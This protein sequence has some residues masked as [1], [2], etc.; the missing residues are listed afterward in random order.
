MDYVH[1]LTLIFFPQYPV[2]DFLVSS[3]VTHELNQPVEENQKENLTS[4]FSGKV[5][6]RFWNQCQQ[7][8]RLSAFHIVLPF[9][10]VISV[11][12][13]TPVLYN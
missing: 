13:S 11:E 12:Q 3:K 9:Y 10:V 8:L 4:I 5:V 1:P 2:Q 7:M 6:G